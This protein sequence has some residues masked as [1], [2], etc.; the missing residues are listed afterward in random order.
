[1]N[2]FSERPRAPLRTRKRGEKREKQPIKCMTA[3]V[4]S[5]ICEKMVPEAL[6]PKIDDR[7]TANS[8]VTAVGIN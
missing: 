5:Q 7:L 4:H 3:A 2:Y 1:M 6:R 8:F